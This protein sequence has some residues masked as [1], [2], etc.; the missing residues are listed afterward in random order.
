MQMKNSQEFWSRLCGLW[1]QIKD[2]ERVSAARF[3]PGLQTHSCNVKYFPS[4]CWQKTLRVSHHALI[5]GMQCCFV[6]Q[7]WARERFSL[8]RHKLQKDIKIMTPMWNRELLFKHINKWNANTRQRWCLAESGVFSIWLYAKISPQIN[9]WRV[10][11]TYF[12]YEKSSK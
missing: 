4:F 6:V 9:F 11:L 8:H 5:S 1:S 3:Q 10:V 12:T 2:M 7:V